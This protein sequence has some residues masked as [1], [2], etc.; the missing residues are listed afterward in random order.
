MYK[1]ISKKLKVQAGAEFQA[2]MEGLRVNGR[3]CN[4]VLGDRY[5]LAFVT[6]VAC[7][8]FL[9]LMWCLLLLS[10]SPQRYFVDDS[11]RVGVV[12]LA[13]E[14]ASCVAAHAILS[15]GHIGCRYRAHEGYCFVSVSSLLTLP[16]VS[17]V[18]TYNTT[19]CAPRLCARACCHAST[20]VDRLHFLCV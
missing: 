16:C 10:S 18:L 11:A 6:R 7:D 15:N 19:V 1:V 14:A 12:A 2:A 5:A 4:I 3:A 9:V 13:R 17:S 8:L 20:A